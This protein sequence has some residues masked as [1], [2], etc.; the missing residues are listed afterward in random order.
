MDTWSSLKKKLKYLGIFSL[1]FLLLYTSLVLPTLGFPEESIITVESGTDLYKLSLKLK[2]EGVARSAFWFRTV[3][4]LLGG[5]R[6]MK[7]GEY[8][9]PYPQ[10]TFAI[11]WRM[12]HGDHGVEVQRITIPEGFTVKKISGLFGDDF[13]L[14]DNKIFE[15]VAPEGYLFP[16]TYFIPL[17]ATASSTI[18]LLQSNFNKKIASLTTDIEDSGRDLEDI[19]K[20]ASIV[21]S[22]AKT[23]ED[24]RIVAGILWKRLKLGIP[25][26][27]DASFVYVNGKTTKDL[28]LD[29]LKIRSPYNTYINKGLPPTPIS[30]PGMESIL[31]ALYPKDTPY[32]YFLTGN[33]GLMYYSKDFD[34]HVAKK[35]KYLK[36]S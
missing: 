32:L 2:E 6:A 30:N 27:V 33:D 26:Q 13:P 19:I 12:V 22:E 34:E 7:A 15:R 14:F 18:N 36:R 21:E 35:R 9:L 24:R 23:G 8:Y 20:M 31:A 16:D 17:S 10:G 25:L 29:D 4:T 1:F 3:S 5:E 28:T 11:A